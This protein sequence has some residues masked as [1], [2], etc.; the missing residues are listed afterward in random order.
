[1]D[2]PSSYWD[3]DV[4]LLSK[5]QFPYVKQCFVAGSLDITSEISANQDQHY[6]KPKQDEKGG[7]NAVVLCN[8]DFDSGE[9][10]QF[11]L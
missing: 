3:L 2:L 8:C 9:N 6:I 4:V 10:T 1:M 11:N 5:C 7:L